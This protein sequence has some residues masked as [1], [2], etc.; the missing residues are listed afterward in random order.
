VRD[1]LIAKG[2][3]MLTGMG[4]KDPDAFR[5]WAR[6]DSESRG[7]FDEALLSFVDNDARPLQWLAKL[8]LAEQG[9]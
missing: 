9:K 1:G 4:V 5:A 7:R 2:E 8:Y 3:A 6:Y